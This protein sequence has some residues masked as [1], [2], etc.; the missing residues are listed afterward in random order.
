MIAALLL[1]GFSIGIVGSFHCVGMCGPIALSLPVY[2]IPSWKKIAFIVLYNAG[3]V[4]AYTLLGIL[5]GVVGMQFFLGG[6]QQVL[7]VSLG[8]LI[9]I[10]LFFSGLS[11]SNFSF[12][13]RFTGFIKKML[14]NLLR[15]EKKFYT[16]ILIGFLNGFLPCG[17]VYVAIAGAVATGS[18]LNSAL[19]MAAFGMGT[20]PIMF[21]VT[22]L[23]KY[24]SLQW[25]NHMKRAVPVFIGVMAVLLILRGLNLGIPF[26]SPEMNSTPAGTVS[27]CHKE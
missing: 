10:F 13:N 8:I 2:D 4:A 14:G 25:R 5:F 15:N 27:C 19:F 21:A 24:I 11:S 6:Y 3:R 16:Y 20:F 26:I 9:L 1:A 18:I 7:S 23:G 22:V 12:I 17:L